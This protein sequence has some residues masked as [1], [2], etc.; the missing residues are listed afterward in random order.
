MAKPIMT[1]EQVAAQ[2]KRIQNN[3]G[4]VSTERTITVGNGGSFYNIPTIFKGVQFSKRRSVERAAQSKFA[5]YQPFADIGTAV[6][7]A[8]ARSKAIGNAIAK[9]NRGSQNSTIGRFK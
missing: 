5:G 6:N 3:D 8:K 9:R 4:S 1:P 2:K 7:A